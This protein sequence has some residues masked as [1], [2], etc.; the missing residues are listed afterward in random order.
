[1]RRKTWLNSI[2]CILAIYLWPPSAHAL[3]HGD[4]D[5]A[6]N[7]VFVGGADGF[8]IEG[9]QGKI[10]SKPDDSTATV[11]FEMPLPITQCAIQ[12]SG[13]NF[14][15]AETLILELFLEN[16]RK[17]DHDGYLSLSSAKINYLSGALSFTVPLSNPHSV[18]VAGMK[19]V[20]NL[21]YY[22]AASGVTEPH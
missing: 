19:V 8:V 14:D 16:G 10:L 15:D 17:Y 22:N 1:M 20:C 18:L 4:H 2:V 12:S 9:I 13:A 6:E 11:A 21:R 5:R 3:E 7:I